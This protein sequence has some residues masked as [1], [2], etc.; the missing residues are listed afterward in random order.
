MVWHAHVHAL[1]TVCAFV[2]DVLDSLQRI[3]SSDIR[4]AA[5]KPSTHAGLLATAQTLVLHKYVSV[6]SE[7]GTVLSVR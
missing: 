3:M 4:V 1:T 6:L 7:L 5:S 2:Q